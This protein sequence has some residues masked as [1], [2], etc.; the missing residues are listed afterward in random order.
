MNAENILKTNDLY[1][2]FKISNNNYATLAENILEIT[3]I[4]KLTIFEKMDEHILGLM[5]FREDIIN[6]INIKTV[7]GLESTPF[8][9]NN[10]IL[11]A[12]VNDNVYGIAIDEIIDITQLAISQINP[13]PYNSQ[14]P[15]INGILNKDGIQTAIL[16]LP[17]MFKNL[18]VK[19]IQKDGETVEFNLFPV[20]DKMS[21]KL[22]KRSFALKKKNDYPD[23]LSSTDKEYRFVSFSLGE[24]IYCLSLKYV[25]EFSKMTKLNLIKIP[26]TPDFFKGV[27]SL[28]GEFINIIDLRPFLGAKDIST[29]SAKSKIIVL[30][31]VDLNIGIIVDDVFEMINIPYQKLKTE[32]SLKFEKNKFI[33]SE[34]VM[35]N[36]KIISVINV[37]KLLKDGC[38]YVG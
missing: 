24:Q 12:T 34:V 19:S 11:V 3:K 31:A 30:N 25:K 15:F 7:L 6:V 29:I 21:R 35:E 10:Q 20:D 37:D 17:E 9:E 14:K 4:P 27:V 18:N 33:L 1:L 22:D 23:F 8:N 13:V 38:L 2:I 5:D 36:N 26:G 28:H 32:N 16:N